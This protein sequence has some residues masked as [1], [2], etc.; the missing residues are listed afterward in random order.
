MFGQTKNSDD[1]YRHYRKRLVKRL[2]KDDIE[3]LKAL[4][5]RTTSFGTGVDAERFN[6][7]FEDRR[8]RI[9]RLSR[10]IDDRLTTSFTYR[11]TVL[12]LVVVG[13]ERA[14]ALLNLIDRILDYLY[15]A[16]KETPNRNVTVGELSSALNVPVDN[17]CEASGY[18]RMASCGSGS[19][20]LPAGPDWHF[21]TSPRSLDYPNLDA[22]LRQH[23]EWTERDTKHG[24]NPVL[25]G[26]PDYIAFW[27]A[28]V[29]GWIGRH[30]VLSLIYVI[31]AALVG[32]AV[33]MF[34]IAGKI[35]GATTRNRW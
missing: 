27:R 12:T 23:V 17:V 32:T 20:G 24:W 34:G 21:T 28:Q 35:L 19:V 7:D 8:G 10:F 33:Y 30:K 26:Y 9:T 4:F 3:I 16:Y 11:P 31:G 22:V 18:I 15:L 13:R 2:E 6:I 25:A 5:E 29:L 14:L 1:P